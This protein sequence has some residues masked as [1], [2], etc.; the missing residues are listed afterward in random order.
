MI[1]SVWCVTLKVS[2]LKKAVAFYEQ[3][4]G[5][6]KKYEY[7]SYAGFQC[8][9][10]EIGLSPGRKESKPLENAPS[11]VFLVDDVDD[12]FKALKKKGVRF[13]EEP[14]DDA[15]GG[16]QAGFLDP[17]SNLLEIVQFNWAKYFEI[18]LKGAKKP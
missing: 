5:L 10:V 14:H 1:K 9:G 6:D 12:A 15:W 8:G 18:S 4:L 17:D 2:D 13:I 7:S 3:T 16:R 11:V